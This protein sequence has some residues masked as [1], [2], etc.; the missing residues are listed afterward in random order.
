MTIPETHRVLK[1]VS[2]HVENPHG[3][4]LFICY[5]FVMVAQSLNNILTKPLIYIFENLLF[6]SLSKYRIRTSGTWS[7]TIEGITR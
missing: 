2:N 7:M 6:Q 5:D 1:S 4:C 3:F